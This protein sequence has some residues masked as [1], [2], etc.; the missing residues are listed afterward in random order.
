[1]AKLE[2]ISDNELIEKIKL[3][4]ELQIEYS[5]L[6]EIQKEANLQLYI[7]STIKKS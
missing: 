7:E 4:K 5:K 3:V 2:I 6:I 1:M